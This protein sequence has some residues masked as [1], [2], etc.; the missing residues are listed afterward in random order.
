MFINELKELGLTEN[1]VKVYLTLLK[2]NY[3]NPTMIAKKTGLHRSYV[4]DTLDRLLDKGIINTVI[5]DNKK[6]YQAVDPNVLRE[7]FELKLKQ[8]DSVLPQLR[9]LFNATK[10]ETRVELYK[11]NRVY[12]TLIKDIIANAKHNDKI[13]ILGV[14]EALL[15]D[16]EPIYFK[17][18]LKIIDEKNIKERIIIAK[19]K[20][21]LS[22]KNLEY[23]EVPFEYIDDTVT[24]IFQ[25][26]VFIFVSESP[27]HLIV[28]EN[29]RVT[30]SYRKQFEIIWASAKKVKNK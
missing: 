11:G 13:C 8:L 30:N 27:A 19:G 14:D 18:Y 23:R 17:Q 12:R 1:E 9:G 16:I 21:I 22:K 2:N 10:Q 6:S 3:L 24:V 25:D 29:K 20:P 4:Y 15:E 26:K 7:I 28:I 5:I